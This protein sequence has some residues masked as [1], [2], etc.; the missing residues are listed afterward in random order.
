MAAAMR[1]A[2]LRLTVRRE[3]TK[4]RRA[5]S[6]TVSTRRG[7]TLVAGEAS[8]LRPPDGASSSGKGEFL[9]PDYVSRNVL[10]VIRRG[11]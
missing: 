2:G 9:N 10:V 5:H 6:R 4:G 1:R 11:V 8:S 7:L 3:A